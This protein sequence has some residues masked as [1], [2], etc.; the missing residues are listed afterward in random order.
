MQSFHAVFLAFICEIIG[1]ISKA[2]A[3]DSTQVFFKAESASSDGILAIVTVVSI[4]S[5]IKMEKMI[6]GIFGLQDSK[7]MGNIGENFAKGMAGIRSAGNLA[8]RTVEPAKRTANLMRERTKNRAD[9]LDA[10]KNVKDK[11]KALEDR[12]KELSNKNLELARITGAKPG[13]GASAEERAEYNEKLKEARAAAKEAQ[14][15]VDKAKDD[16][17]SAK[18]DVISKENKDKDLTRDIKLSSVQTAS[19]MGSTVAAGAFGIGATDSLAEAAIVANMTDSVLDSIANPAIKNTIYGKAGEEKQR[20][21]TR[22]QNQLGDDAGLERTAK[23]R[24]R[25][26]YPSLADGSSEFAAKVK[27]EKQE[28]IKEIKDAI[29]VASKSKLELDMELPT[30]KLKQLGKIAGDTL[31]EGIGAFSADSRAGRGYSRNVRKN[32]IE[33]KGTNISNVDDI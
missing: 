21:I 2:Y 22:L 11:D 16:L 18:K 6:K 17:R 15:K 10:R 27:I 7:F 4:M 14:G 19:T 33:Y 29:D 25:T 31:S 12:R 13:N 24:V 28:L 8:K 3:E 23:E 32:G 26:S 5:L 1:G 20:T 9:I 30:S